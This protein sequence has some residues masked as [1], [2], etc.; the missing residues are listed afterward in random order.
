MSHYRIFIKHKTILLIFLL[1]RLGIVSKI[2]FRDR[3]IS[4]DS[5][6]RKCMYSRESLPVSKDIFVPNSVC[7]KRSGVSAS[8]L[9]Y[10]IISGI[11]IYFEETGS[12]SILSK[13]AS[14]FLYS[15]TW[16]LLNGL[17]KESKCKNGKH[18]ES[19]QT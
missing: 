3:F 17:A 4:P 6:T 13:K 8:Q 1:T 7:I 11:S 16:S 18:T 2:L 15:W 9:S 5:N 19:V 10:S 14:V 12:I